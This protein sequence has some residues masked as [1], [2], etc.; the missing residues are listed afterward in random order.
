[1]GGHAYGYFVPYNP[2][3]QQA[4]DDLRSREFKAGRYNPAVP[5]PAFPATDKA[6]AARPM[7]AS[8]EEVMEDMDEDGTRSILDIMTVA[9][10]PDFCTAGP[11]PESTLKKLYGTAQPTRKQVEA[12]MAFLEDVERGQ[13]VYILLHQGAN[14]IEIFFTGISFD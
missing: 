9:D 4:L 13:C 1:M 14:P 12:N 5:F 3:L 7:H 2:D 11:V 10:A 8:I 6:P